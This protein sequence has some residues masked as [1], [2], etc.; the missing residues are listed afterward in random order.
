MGWS[1]ESDVFQTYLREILETFPWFLIVSTT[2]HSFLEGPRS[3]YEEKDSEKITSLATNHSGSEWQFSINSQW[4]NS[5]EQLNQVL[6]QAH[7]SHSVNIHPSKSVFQTE[8]HNCLNR[9]KLIVL[10]QIRVTH[11]PH[12]RIQAKAYDQPFWFY[13]KITNTSAWITFTNQ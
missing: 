6:N 3:S 2:A 13:F 5:V 4:R 1:P 11:F 12:R 10:I 8:L 9:V 7:S